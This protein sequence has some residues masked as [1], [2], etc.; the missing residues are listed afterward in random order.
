MFTE[1]VS[2]KKIITRRVEF[3]GVNLTK[4]S[5]S[6]KHNDKNFLPQT[7]VELDE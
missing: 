2:L 6:F 7:K 4:R 3:T 5:G 1:Y